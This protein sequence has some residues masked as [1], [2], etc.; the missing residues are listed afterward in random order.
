MKIVEISM[1]ISLEMSG[2]TEEVGQNIG[3][4]EEACQNIGD[5]SPTN[6]SDISTN[7][8]DI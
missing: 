5:I 2:V 1:I 7:I 6:T 3:I 4:A 8:S